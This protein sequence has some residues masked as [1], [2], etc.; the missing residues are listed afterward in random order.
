MASNLNF[1]VRQETGE[2]I[3]NLETSLFCLI[4]PPT[5]GGEIDAAV[6]VLDSSSI[7]KSVSGLTCGAEI[8]RVN[9]PHFGWSLE[10]TGPGA[11]RITCLGLSLSKIST[12]SISST[13]SQTMTVSKNGGLLGISS[14]MA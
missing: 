2:V 1:R 6:E 14:M 5:T 7:S 4:G 10:N 12:S 13:G 8:R 3:I 9:D 11:A